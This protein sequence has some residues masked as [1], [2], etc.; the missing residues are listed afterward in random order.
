MSSLNFP[1]I[2]RGNFYNPIEKNTKSVANKYSV[3]LDA[4]DV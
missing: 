3:R 1:E 4:V 2:S